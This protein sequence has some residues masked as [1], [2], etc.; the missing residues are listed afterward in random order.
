MQVVVFHSA[1][2]LTDG[3]RA[4]AE[5]LRRDG[6]DVLVP[7]LYEGRTFATTPEGVAHRDAVGIETL[8]QRGLDAVAHLPNDIVTV[9]FS[10]GAALASFLA[11]TR[12]GARGV[13]LLHGAVPLALLG[14][15]TWPRVPV[16]LHTSAD[17]PFVASDD[18]AS[19]VASVH[20]SGAPCRHHVYPASGHLF[21]EPTAVEHDAASA[22]LAFDRVRAFVQELRDA[23]R[24]AA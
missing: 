5:I 23:S 15:E 12:P 9:G 11:C 14:A 2:G 4:L 17:D 10:M 7:D 20:E 19:F 1:I 24:L 8:L 22:T 3:V 13:V 6:H 21:T 16:S 18:V